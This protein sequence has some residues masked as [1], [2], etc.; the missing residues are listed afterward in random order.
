MAY[1]KS[2]RLAGCPVNKKIVAAA[3]IGIVQAHDASL[4]LSSGGKMKLGPGWAESFLRRHRYVRRKGTKTARHIP[5]DYEDVRA[6]FYQRICDFAA[7]YSIPESLVV[8]ID[9]TGIKLVPVAEYTLEEKGNLQ[10]F[11]L[12]V[13]KPGEIQTWIQ[14]PIFVDYRSTRRPRQLVA[15]ISWSTR[16]QF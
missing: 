5:P 12:K 14:A 13:I 11:T 16:R 8:N 3:A 4:L 2:L 1:V 7:K 10:I 6:G 15:R 9:Q